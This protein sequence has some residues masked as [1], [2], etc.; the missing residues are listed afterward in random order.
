MELFLMFA[1]A[2][3]AF[4]FL[5][6]YNTRGDVF[7]GDAMVVAQRVEAGSGGGNWRTS[8]WNYLTTFRFTDGQELE[9]YVTEHEYYQL[10]VGATGQVVWYQN[11]LSRFDADREVIT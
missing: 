1:I 7:T 6:W 3:V 11:T 10:E 2:L 9:L 4:G 5:A 8:S